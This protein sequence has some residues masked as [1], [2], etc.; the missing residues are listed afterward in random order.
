MECALRTKSGKYRDVRWQI[1]F[2]PVRPTDDIVLF[3]SART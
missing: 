1:A 2:A 3:P